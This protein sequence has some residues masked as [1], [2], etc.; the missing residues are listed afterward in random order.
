M[1]SE[2]FDFAGLFGESIVIKEWTINKLPSDQFSISNALI[3][4][5][6]PIQSIIIDPQYQANIWIKTQF[7]GNRDA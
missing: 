7:T 2:S 1:V 3:I 5:Q 6:S 4:D